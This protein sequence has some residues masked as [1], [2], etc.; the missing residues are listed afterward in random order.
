M[1]DEQS[2]LLKEAME[3]YGIKPSHVLAS[4]EYGD[5]VVIVTKGG[6]RASFARGDHVQKLRQAELDGQIP[7]AGRGGRKKTEVREIV[8]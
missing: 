2:P 3:A 4:R 8:G 7:E 6:R 5:H 1:I